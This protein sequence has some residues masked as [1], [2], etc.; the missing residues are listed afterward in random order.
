M[1]VTKR[2]AVLALGAAA[3]TIG[4]AAGPAGAAMWPKHGGHGWAVRC[5]PTQSTAGRSADHRATPMI[6]MTHHRFA[7]STTVVPGGTLAPDRPP[8]GGRPPITVEP[9]DVLFPSS[10]TTVVASPTASAT[11][12]PQD[13]EPQDRVHTTPT[14]TPSA[15]QPPITIEPPDV[16]YSGKLPQER[17]MMTVAPPEIRHG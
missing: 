9:P 6:C 1:K 10:P 11:I 13:R 17:S 3:L 15:S 7:P 8:V 16:L 4:L 14:T 12:P 2:K 5:A